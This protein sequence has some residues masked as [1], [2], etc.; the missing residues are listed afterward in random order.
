MARVKYTLY[1]ARNLNFTKTQPETQNLVLESYAL[2]KPVHAHVRDGLLK[3]PKP[4]PL[5][6]KPQTPNPKPQTLHPKL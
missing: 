6:P 5:N 4:R 2:L 3:D 1:A